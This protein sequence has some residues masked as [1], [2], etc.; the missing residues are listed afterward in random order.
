MKA[1]WIVLTGVSVIGIAVQGSAAQGGTQNAAPKVKYEDVQKIFTANC[2][3][4][5][6]GAR[7]RG[8]IDLSSYDHV[9]KGGEDGPVVVSGNLRK[10][11]LYQAVSHAQ[12]FRPMPPTGVKL[13]DT[14]VNLIRDW[15]SA[16][17]KK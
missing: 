7:P 16:G 13:P 10:S 8:K 4:C 14:D 6:G 15:I 5:H 9:M 1:A 2:I 12:G 17:A 3:G 11:P